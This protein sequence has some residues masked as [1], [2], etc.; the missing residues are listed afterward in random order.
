MGKQH[1]TLINRVNNFLNEHYLGCFMLPFLILFTSYLVLYTQ[2]RYHMHHSAA[3]K[4][5][6]EHFTTSYT[7]SGS[8]TCICTVFYQADKKWYIGNVNVSRK[9]LE[10]LKINANTYPLI[11]IN[12]STIAPDKFIG[13]Y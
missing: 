2:H 12:V 1:H 4:A 8:S 9:D 11:P 13:F 7:H 3:G 6:I 5:Y 10:L